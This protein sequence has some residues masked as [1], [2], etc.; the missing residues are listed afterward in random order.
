M[1]TGSYIPQIHLSC[2]RVGDRE[3]SLCIGTLAHLAE[4]GARSPPQKAGHDLWLT[5]G[6]H[7]LLGGQEH[8]CKET[9]QRFPFRPCFNFGLDLDLDVTG[10][11]KF[12]SSQAF[13]SAAHVR[14]KK[15][16]NGKHK[17]R[18]RKMHILI[19]PKSRIPTKFFP[20]TLSSRQSFVHSSPHT[21]SA[22]TPSILFQFFQS[23]HSFHVNHPCTRL[24]THHPFPSSSFN[25]FI[26]FTS[27]FC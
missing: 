15:K 11:L 6:T 25:H 2:F 12:P 24:P 7:S 3:Y 21:V 13:V 20:E 8:G 5:S 4:A 18:K 14:R 22:T 17:K 16:K 19:V 27:H 26:H 9:A 23:L 1:C 10:D